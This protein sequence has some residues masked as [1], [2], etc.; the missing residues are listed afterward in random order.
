MPFLDLEQSQSSARPIEL[1]EFI[2]TFQTWRITSYQAPITSAG[3]TYTPVPGLERGI[4]KVGTQAEDSL[5]LDITLPS[6]HPMVAAYAYQTAPPRLDLTIR[7]VH[8]DDLASPVTMWKGSVTAFTVEGRLAK[9]RVPSI[10]ASALQGI[11]PQPRFQ[12]PCNHLL[13]DARCKVSQ[14]ANQH[15]TTITGY[16][17]RVVTVATNPF[18]PGDC[19]AGEMAFSLGSQSRM[20]IS[21]TGLDF[22]VSYPFSGVAVGSQVIIRRGCDRSFQTCRDKFANGANFGGHPLVPALN[23]FTSSL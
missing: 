18:A 21:N 19:N 23:P 20:I 3:N 16:A 9:F 13:F 22:T 1:F 14:A 11:A 4:L 2:G 15:I 12:A 10:F 17:G 7:R 8:L 6:D 5:S